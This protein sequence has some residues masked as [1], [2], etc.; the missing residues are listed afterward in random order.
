MVNPSSGNATSHD[1]FPDILASD[2]VVL[3]MRCG[4][5]NGACGRIQAVILNDRKVRYSSVK[6]HRFDRS[7]YERPEVYDAFVEAL[8]KR[9][10]ARRSRRAFKVP[11]IFVRPLP[12]HLRE[13]RELRAE[14]DWA[15]FEASDEYGVETGEDEE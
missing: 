9:E 2:R 12:R 15:L 6:C 14:R 3:I 1:D 4:G 13:D 5:R 10:S 8:K 7:F 11:S